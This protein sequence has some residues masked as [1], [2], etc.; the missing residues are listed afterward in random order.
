MTSE[1]PKPPTRREILKPVELVLLSAGLALFVGVVVLLSTRQPL[2]AVV[3][4]G[5]AFIVSLVVIAMFT[6]TFKPN[7]AE[8]QELQGE[9]EAG[10]GAGG[11]PGPYLG[12]GPKAH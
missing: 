5:I 10:T 12:P 4:F 8:Q 7:A 1:D 9:D 6:L 11:V 2:L 3:F